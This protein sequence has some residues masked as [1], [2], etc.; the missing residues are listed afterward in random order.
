MDFRNGLA[1]ARTSDLKAIVRI[2][3]ARTESE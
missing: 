1:S 2:N 3:A